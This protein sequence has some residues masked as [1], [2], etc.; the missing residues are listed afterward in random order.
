[1]L[2]LRR[3]SPPMRMVSPRCSMGGFA[4]KSLM[5]FSGLSYPQPDARAVACT[6]TFPSA[7]PVTE[8]SPEVL[9]ISRRMGAFTVSVRSKLPVA[10]G[11]M[12]QPAASA[13][14]A[15][16]PREAQNC[17]YLIDPPT[18]PCTTFYQKIRKG[19][20]SCS[21]GFGQSLVERALAIAFEV[22]GNILESG[23]F[24]G[25][26]D[27]GGHVHGQSARQFVGSNFDAGELVVEAHAELLESQVPQSGF[28]ALYE[29]EAFGC[30]FGSVGKARGGTRG[31]GTVPGRQACAL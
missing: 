11:P 27:G 10:A 2:L 28:A 20:R 12:A 3:N 22:Q 23:G 29:A 31:S 26:G 6:C 19:A 25:F 7:L 1:M 16:D 24:Q 5:R 21:R 13:I 9:L 15:S 30:H 14:N 8:T 17:R 18:S 4:S